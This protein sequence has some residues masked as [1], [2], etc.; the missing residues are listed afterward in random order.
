MTEEEERKALIK[1]IKMLQRICSPVRNPEIIT[2]ENIRTL[3]GGYIFNA[4]SALKKIQDLPK[5]D[6]EMCLRI[7]SANEGKD[8]GCRFCVLKKKRKLKKWTIEFNS[9]EDSSLSEETM[10]MILGTQWY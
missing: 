5:S 8:L 7:I 4:E 1:E 2:V 6:K 3:D 10:G 9:T